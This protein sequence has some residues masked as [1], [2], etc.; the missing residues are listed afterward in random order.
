MEGKK[1][2]VYHVSRDGQPGWTS[3]NVLDI[4]DAEFDGAEIGD[5]ITLT[6]GEMTEEEISKLPEF[7]GW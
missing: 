6:L 3:K 7:E 1:V 5:S 2:K 4:V